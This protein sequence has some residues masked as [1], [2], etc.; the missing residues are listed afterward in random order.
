MFAMFANLELFS[1][2]LRILLIEVTINLQ[3]NSIRSQLNCHLHGWVQ[4]PE[5]PK[6]YGLVTFNDNQAL[7]IIY[8]H[9]KQ[10]H[11]NWYLISIL[12]VVCGALKNTCCRFLRCNQRKYVANFSTENIILIFVFAIIKFNAKC[13]DPLLLK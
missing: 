3:A 9:G 10:Q 11:V 7:L 2:I 8:K 1:N 5:T 13:F 4:W 12:L 6:P